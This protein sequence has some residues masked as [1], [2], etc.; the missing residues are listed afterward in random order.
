M[1]IFGFI[2]NYITCEAETQLINNLKP[3]SPGLSGKINLNL[4]DQITLWRDCIYVCNSKTL[5]RLSRFAELP[6]NGNVA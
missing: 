1:I 6:P 2:T 5:I 3:L 4:V